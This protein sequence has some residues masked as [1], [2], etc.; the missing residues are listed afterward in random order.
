MGFPFDIKIISRF[1][2]L[3]VKNIDILN[4]KPYKLIILDCDNTL[5]GGV[6]DE[7]V[8]MVSNIMKMVLAKRLESF[9]VN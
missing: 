7:K 2:Y 6:L 3:I 4:S 9:K 1:K 5:W 8:C